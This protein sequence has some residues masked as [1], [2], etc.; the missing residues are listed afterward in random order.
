MSRVP[1]LRFSPKTS[2]NGKGTRPTQIPTSLRAGPVWALG[3]SLEDSQ[4]FGAIP[5]DA[6][7]TPDLK[8]V[9]FIGFEVIRLALAPDTDAAHLESVV[10]TDVALTQRLLR[11]ANSARYGRGYP[12][13][14][15]REAVVHLGFNEL[16]RVAVATS[17][18]DLAGRGSAEGFDR[19]GFFLHSLAVGALA[20]E[21]SE[22][23]GFEDP[24]IAFVAGLLHDVGKA[25]FDQHYPRG[26]DGKVR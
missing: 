1:L 25:F 4:E 5:D 22:A 18:L 11:I 19:L 9:P 16:R 24:P 21:I 6:P 12:V 23:V 13:Q 2:D 26:A 10:Q 8:T 7:G 20:Q 15:V 3:D 14:T 17:V